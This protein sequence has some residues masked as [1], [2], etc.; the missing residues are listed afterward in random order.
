MENEKKPLGDNIPV[1]ALCE[2]LDHY[3]RRE[4][5][6]FREKSTS[7]HIFRELVAVANWLSGGTRW[8]A[9]EYAT[10]WS[11]MPEVGWRAAGIAA[12]SPPPES[13]LPRPDVEPEAMWAR[14]G[15][16]TRYRV[17]GR[18][19]SVR[20]IVGWDRP[21]STF[22]AQVWDVPESA[23]HHEEGKLLLWLGT[24]FHEA[25][26]IDELAETLRPF[27]PLPVDHTA[28]RA[29]HWALEA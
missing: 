16:S 27:V 9:E 29:Q 6:S 5:Q 26:T 8:D 21:M 2:V 13:E 11:I 12:K 17:L 10:S 1:E 7:C 3:W 22:F 4:V 24:S 14:E 18:K 28:N 19:P 20:V 15:H 23:R 25:E